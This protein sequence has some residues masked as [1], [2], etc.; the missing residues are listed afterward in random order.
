[1]ADETRMFSKISDESIEA[2]K[3]KTY[4]SSKLMQDPQAG[5]FFPEIAGEGAVEDAETN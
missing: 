2:G 5:L 1:M 3:G 4:T